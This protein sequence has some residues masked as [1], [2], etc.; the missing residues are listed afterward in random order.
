MKKSAA[1]IIRAKTQAGKKVARRL[2]PKIKA[3]HVGVAFLTAQITD[4][5]ER[6]AAMRNGIN[7]NGQE[8]PRRSE[9]H[10]SELQS[11]M[12]LVCRLLLE[13][14][15]KKK[16]LRIQTTHTNHQ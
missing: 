12:Y 15:K 1:S 14:K 8:K 6:C 13:K 11:P 9:E 4:L 16:Q 5:E 10:T 3:S 2:A 7:N